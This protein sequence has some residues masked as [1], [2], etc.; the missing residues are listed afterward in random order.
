MFKSYIT[1]YYSF[2]DAYI[3]KPECRVYVIV[4]RFVDLLQWRKQRSLER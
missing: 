1:K 3:G 2:N 4:N